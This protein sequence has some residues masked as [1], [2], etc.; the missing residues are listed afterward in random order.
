MEAKHAAAVVALQHYNSS[1]PMH[2]VLPPEYRYVINT[3][4]H[5]VCVCCVCLCVLN[6]FVCVKYDCVC[7]TACRYSEL[8]TH[9]E[10]HTDM[11]FAQR[12]EL[13]LV[14]MLVFF[15][16][17]RDLWFQVCEEDKKRKEEKVAI[18]FFCFSAYASLL[19]KH[20]SIFPT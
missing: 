3:T 16:A 17:H 8:S 4:M 7:D 20:I 6:V 1:L 11:P 12:N 5:V 13:M 9:S 15:F 19:A 18:G 14:L 2:R 10:R